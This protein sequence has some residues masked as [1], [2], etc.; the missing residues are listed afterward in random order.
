[1]TDDAILI[2][3]RT[4]RTEPRPGRLGD[5]FRLLV[6]R[7]LVVG[8]V[9]G[10]LAVGVAALKAPNAFSAAPGAAAVLSAAVIVVWIALIWTMRPFFRSQT[11]VTRAVIRVISYDGRAFTWIEGERVLTAVEAPSFRLTTRPVPPEIVDDERA[12]DQPWPVWLVVQSDDGRFVLETKVTAEEASA[13]P[14]AAPDVEAGADEKL[15][16]HVASPLLVLGRHAH[17]G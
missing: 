15:P 9:G 17:A 13:Y 3:Y 6:R 5:L 10:I 7:P 2:H 8:I 16:T 14:E 1:M 12:R 4:E 11:T